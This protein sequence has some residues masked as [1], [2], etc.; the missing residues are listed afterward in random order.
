M[1][2]IQLNLHPIRIRVS[3]FRN[4]ACEQL[5][6]S[7][8]EPV[9]S[10]RKTAA[11][12]MRLHVAWSE[13]D[14]P[15]N[16]YRWVSTHTGTC[17]SLHVMNDERAGVLEDSI[18]RGHRVGQ[19]RSAEQRC[20]RSWRVREGLDERGASSLQRGLVVFPPDVTISIGC[21]RVSVATRARALDLLHEW[22]GTQMLEIVLLV[23]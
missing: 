20:D 13:R 12:K 8:N 14:T 9:L 16:V 4:C 17:H 6:S 22:L 1:T 10:K 7:T 18:L 15:H 21:W 5:S 19:L 3:V 2:D 23:R 11:D